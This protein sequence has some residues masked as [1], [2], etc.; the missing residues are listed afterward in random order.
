VERTYTIQLCRRGAELVV[1]GYTNAYEFFGQPEQRH[2][3]CDPPPRWLAVAAFTTTC[4]GDGVVEQRTASAG[5]GSV[6]IDGRTLAALH[7]VIETSTRGSTDGTTHEEL[8]L[9]RL[10]G[11]VLRLDRT[12]R[13]ETSTAVGAAAYQEHVELV[14]SVLTPVG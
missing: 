7:V 12:V 13:N 10:T 6:T 1:V 14:V 2:L 4:T 9:D 11:L 8:W 5:D 3:V